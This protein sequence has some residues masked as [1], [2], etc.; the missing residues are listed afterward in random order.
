[1]P[2]HVHGDDTEG[3]VTI[4][5][6][7]QKKV[8]DLCAHEDEWIWVLDE[9]APLD[10]ETPL[11]E[12]VASHRIELV[13]HRCRKINVTVS[14]NGLEAVF[15]VPPALKIRALVRKS[16][17]VPEFEIDPSSA[18]DLELRLPGT[19]EGLD[20]SLPIGRF[21]GNGKCELALNLVSAIKHAG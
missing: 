14:Y 10:P 19:E 8:S 12:L 5:D 1:M 21:V 16:L 18:A 9:D 6:V 3:V 15:R 17:K 2:I 13:K 20:S 4:D 11:A 7:G